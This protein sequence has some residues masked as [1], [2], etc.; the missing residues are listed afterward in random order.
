M[1]VSQNTA[2]VA[3]LQY[4]Q[5]QAAA[6]QAQQA[7]AVAYQAQ[8]AQAAVY[9]AQ[10]P[11]MMPAQPLYQQSAYA[12]TNQMQGTIRVDGNEWLE[13]PAASGAH[14]VRDVSTGQWTRKI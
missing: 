8:Q 12:P 3:N 5:D 11:V 14:Y 4:Q 13:Y 9:Q 7:Q 1:Q 10:Q 6:Y 2:Q